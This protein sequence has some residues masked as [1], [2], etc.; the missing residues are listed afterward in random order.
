MFIVYFN[1]ER[2]CKISADGQNYKGTTE[3]AQG[4]PCLDWKYFQDEMQAKYNP[5]FTVE[6]PTNPQLSTAGSSCRYGRY[7]DAGSTEEFGGLS[8]VTSIY[9]WG[10]DPEDTWFDYE[11]CDVPLCC[12]YLHVLIN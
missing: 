1:T 9:N 3:L 12:K 4:Y 8:C 7:N 2:N 6:L 10:D 5:N 11:T